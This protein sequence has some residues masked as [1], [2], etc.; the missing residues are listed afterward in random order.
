[1]GFIY[2]IRF[3]IRVSLFFG[4]KESLFLLNLQFIRYFR[5][6]FVFVSAMKKIIFPKIIILSLVILNGGCTVVPG[7]HLS[8]SNKNIVNDKN[9]PV[10][11][12]EL[13]DIYPI[14]PKIIASLLVP[15]V[16]AQANP[17]LEALLQEYHYRIG[18][19]DILMVTVW[20]HPEL[21]TPAGQ[22]RSASDTGNWVQANGNI[23][24]PYAGKVHVAGKT[25]EDVRTTLTE[26]LAPWIESPQVDVSVADF[27]SQKA[28]ITGEVANSGQQA[29]TNV[30][31]TIVDALNKAG[32]LT[33]FA[34]WNHAVLSRAGKKEVISLKALLKSGDLTQNRLLL[35]GDIFYVPRNDDLKVFVMGEVNKQTMLK[36]DS[37]GMT[38]AE[39]LGRA[40]GVNQITSDAT[41]IFIIRALRDKQSDNKIAKI[42]QLNASD[43]S[44]LVMGAAFQLEPYDIVYVTSAPIARWNRVIS[45]L[46]PTISGIKDITETTR[47]IR[48][49]NE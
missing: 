43:A 37:S 30:P 11:V 34:D 29:I 19:G 16:T 1:M 46:I 36:M 14:S 21:T 7:T 20:D 35:A 39:A 47:F 49:W 28:Y 42:Y 17:S 12:N 4:H 18:V 15:S 3:L 41:G 32:G 2:I 38:L 44:A 10:D 13:V 24:Y 27:R 33:E 48:G 8:L 5:T 6:T 25:L 31:L 22:Y 26:K 45:Q 9:S 40:E 23:F